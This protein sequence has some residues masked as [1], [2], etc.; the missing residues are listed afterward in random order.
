VVHGCPG[1]E[2]APGFGSTPL[3]VGCTGLAQPGRMVGEPHGSP[4]PRHAVRRHGCRDSPRARRGARGCTGPSRLPQGGGG[5]KTRRSR[6]QTVAVGE[7]PPRA[8]VTPWG[9]PAQRPSR[10]A[11]E[12]RGVKCSGDREP[13]TRSAAV[14]HRVSRACSDA[15]SG[16]RKVWGALG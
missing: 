6:S 1:S 7:M 12:T 15:R 11:R 10:Q 3:G 14:C 4:M 2:G 9:A 16:A 8:S 13:A 5:H